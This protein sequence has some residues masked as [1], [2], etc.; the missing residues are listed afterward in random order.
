MLSF[1][2][3][4]LVPANNTSTIILAGALLVT[5]LVSY[6]DD[7]SF[8]NCAAAAPLTPRRLST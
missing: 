4:A 1:I 8:A 6:D 5:V 3:W 7:D 2:S